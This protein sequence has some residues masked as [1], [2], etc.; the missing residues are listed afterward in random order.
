M[1]RFRWPLRLG[2]MLLVPLLLLTS[3]ELGLRLFGYGYQWRFFRPVPGTELLGSNTAFGYRFFPRAIA[4]TPLFYSFEAEKPQNTYRI[5]LLGASAAQGFPNPAVGFSQILDEM[6]ED[7]FPGVDFD[8]VNT[9][10]PA[11]NSHVVLPIARECAGYDPDLFLVYLGNNEVIGPFNAGSARQRKRVTSKSVQF[12]VKSRTTKIGQLAQAIGEAVQGN[13]EVQETWGGMTMYSDNHFRADDPVLQGVYD[14]F[15]QNLQGIVEAAHTAGAKVLLSTVSVNLKD[16]APFF[17]LHRADLSETRLQQWTQAYLETEQL[18]QAGLVEE[19]VAGFKALL[20]MDDEFAEVH[21]RL[22]L[23]LEA[24]G[25]GDE[26][27]E[28]F[29]AALDYDALPF[30]SN[31]KI[32]DVLRSVAKKNQSRAVTLLDC[33]QQMLD[34]T[35]NQGALPG[36][37][38][39]YEHVHLTFQGNYQLARIMF[40]AVV[41]LLP[42]EIL[43]SRL[44]SRPLPGPE[45][46]AENLAFSNY[47]RYNML[48]RIFVLARKAPFTNQFNHQESLAKIEQRLAFLKDPS[49]ADEPRQLADS[50]L[51][52]LGRRPHDLLLR[53]NFAQLLL[54]LGDQA[55]YAGQMDLVAARLPEIEAR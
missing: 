19:S 4:R 21:F 22:A 48:S 27:L 53:N 12:V 25:R 44:S 37:N 47:D 32:N 33:R 18:V 51:R 3:L 43:A 36:E 15:E 28:H 42:P 38:E 29:Q 13:H 1:D 35:L 46:C 34:W 54:A 50:F 6:L 10:M 20:A 23:Q 11:I 40:N 17:S 55:G 9:G 41:G 49:I 24:L 26:A 2:M 45:Q 30:R 16:S 5:F 52:A 39:F 8:L 14:N 31:R 7:Q